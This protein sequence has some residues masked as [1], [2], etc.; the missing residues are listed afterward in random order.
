M[1]RNP[2]AANPC[3]S[4]AL[5]YCKRAWSVIPLEPQ[6]KRPSVKGER[7]QSERPTSADARQWWRK[8]PNA[9]VGIVTGRINKL[10]V[11][12]V[13]PAKGGNQTLTDL[14]QEHGALPKTVSV[15]TG[16]G[17]QHFYF[18]HAGVPIPNCAGKLGPGLD[19]RGEGGYVVAPPSIHLSGKPYEW[20]ATAFGD[21]DPAPLPLWLLA[22]LSD[23]E[24]RRT[25]ATGEQQPIVKGERNTVLTSLAGSMRRRGMTEAA[26]QSALLI[27]NAARCKP[28][29][30]KEDVQEIAISVARY[31]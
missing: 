19:V 9:N 26:I 15:R 2:R 20:G 4:A 30:R 3:L 7:Y 12:D 28:P 24:R 17:G 1:P 5:D 11:L 14:E 18:Q 29:L 10:V 31:E 25:P 27:E 21:A 23:P 22:R 13:D 6:G 16:G 8:E